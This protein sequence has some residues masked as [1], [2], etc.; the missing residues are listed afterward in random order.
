MV[1]GVTSRGPAGTG[2]LADFSMSTL[3]GYDAVHSRFRPASIPPPTIDHQETEARHVA[4]SRKTEKLSTGFGELALIY[5][6]CQSEVASPGEPWAIT[7]VPFSN[8]S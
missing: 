2:V 4:S 5:W 7:V 6:I 8:H 1:T 3:S